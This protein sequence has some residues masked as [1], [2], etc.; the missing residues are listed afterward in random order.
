MPPPPDPPQQKGI[1][2]ASGLQPTSATK[3]A[4][5]SRPAAGSRARTLAPEPPF[6]TRGRLD[7][8]EAVRVSPLPRISATDSL[9]NPHQISTWFWFS[10]SVALLLLFSSRSIGDR[11]IVKPNQVLRRRDERRVS[12]GS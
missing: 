4:R 6:R 12:S 2:G 9:L 1:T 5:C 7:W 8:G 3:S 10:K 11:Q